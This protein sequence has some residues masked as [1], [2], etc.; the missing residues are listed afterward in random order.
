MKRGA[1]ELSTHPEATGQDAF[2]TE[3][4]IPLPAWNAA[5]MAV[6]EAVLG[7]HEFGWSRLCAADA[8]DVVDTSPWLDDSRAEMESCVDNTPTAAN[9]NAAT[10]PPRCPQMRITWC[11]PLHHLKQIERPFVRPSGIRTG[12]SRPR[13]SRAVSRATHRTASMP[14]LP[15]TTTTAGSASERDGSNVSRETGPRIAQPLEAP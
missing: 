1:P 7:R 11:Q 3:W 6:G 2:L 8:R 14:G 9:A 12:T 15:G 4:L 10:V 5:Q 13:D